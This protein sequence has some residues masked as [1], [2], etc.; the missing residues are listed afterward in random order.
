MTDPDVSRRR[1]LAGAA[2]LGVGVPLLAACGGNDSS[3]AGPAPTPGGTKVPRGD[4][5]SSGGS[6]RTPGLVASAD[7]PVGG[8]VILAS[9][10]IVVTQPKK[11]EFKAFAA[12]CTHQGCQVASVAGGTINCPCHGSRF[13]I[14]DG[15]NVA[16][17]SGTAAGSIAPLSA[18]SVKVKG[19]EVV[20]G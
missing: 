16:G 13:S 2:A 4:A 3:A 20:E 5:S 17:P 18:K 12:T 14:T 10:N 15:S 8:G 11:G 1:A 9:Q 7:V 6:S 19:T